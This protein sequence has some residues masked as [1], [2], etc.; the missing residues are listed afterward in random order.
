MFQDV[1]HQSRLVP[2]YDALDRGNYRLALKLCSRREVNTFNLVKALQSHA[3][4]RLGQHSQAIAVAREAAILSGTTHGGVLDTAWNV[5]RVCGAAHEGRRMYISAWSRLLQNPSEAAANPDNAHDIALKYVAAKG[6]SVGFNGVVH[7]GG[8]GGGG[9]GG[10]GSGGGGGGDRSGV[11]GARGGSDGGSSG[12]AGGSSGRDHKGSS[13]PN[14]ASG[15]A[16]AE[17]KAHCLSMFKLFK[18]PLYVVWGALF[19]AML[20]EHELQ[21]AEDKRVVRALVTAAA[22]AVTIAIPGEE[23]DSSRGAASGDP[24]IV[25]TS[26]TDALRLKLALGTLERVSKAMEERASEAATAS[27]ADGGWGDGNLGGGLAQGSAL[28]ASI[29]QVREL[30]L[31]LLAH[32]N[33]VTEGGKAAP[34]VLRDAV[35]EYVKQDAAAEQGPMS[36]RGSGM[37]VGKLR[38]EAAAA[39]GDIVRARELFRQCLETPG[40]RIPA[41]SGIGDLLRSL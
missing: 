23:R 41:V 40:G 8:S 16:L 39:A 27:R 21:E 22:D 30:R 24:E 34:Y 6:A 7:M 2:I 17:L 9:G 14:N 37:D 32:L 36:V 19:A 29:W 13:G 10:G 15:K 31:L 1:P 12:G 26:G 33:T 28:L 35:E 5:L 18:Q 25:K 3:L 20:H 38:A 11:G 4:Y